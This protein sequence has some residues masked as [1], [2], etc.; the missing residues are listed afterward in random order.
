VAWSTGHKMNFNTYIDT[1]KKRFRRDRSPEKSGI[2]RKRN[3]IGI[4]HDQIDLTKKQSALIIGAANK[5]EAKILA[6]YGIKRIVEI[7]IIANHPGIMEMD[8]HDLKFSSNDFDY[9]QIFHCLEHS[10][11]YHT[12]INEICRVLKPGGHIVIEVPV[13]FKTTDIDRWDF[14][15]TGKVIQEFSKAT[16]IEAIYW[17][18]IEKNEQDN[19]CGT[20]ISRIII[21]KVEK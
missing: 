10:Y 11:N 17:K 19:F 12:V 3:F 1:Q 14:K 16:Q 4:I 13:N 20:D 5:N 9:V 21:K 6:G 2:D 8:M 18:D 7:D 15:N